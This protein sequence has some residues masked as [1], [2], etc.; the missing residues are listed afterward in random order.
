[1]STQ[2]TELLKN[3]KLSSLTNGLLFDQTITTA[4]YNEIR[5]WVHVF[6]EKYQTTPVTGS[7]KL[8]VR[9]MHQFTGGSFDYVN[10]TFGSSVASYINGYTAQRIIG[11]QTRIL[12]SPENLPAGPWDVSLTVYLVG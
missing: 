7:T 9:L 12:C 2:Y 4:G 10:A 5:V 8:K 3:V 6:V 1:M 11:D